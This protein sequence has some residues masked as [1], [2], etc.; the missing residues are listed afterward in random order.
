MA[1]Y[2]VIRKQDSLFEIRGEF[3]SAVGDPIEIHVMV[4]IIRFVEC[5]GCSGRHV[6]ST[7]CLLTPSVKWSRERV[8]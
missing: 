2:C 5:C 8:I 4:L 7:R 1:T 6:T 3:S